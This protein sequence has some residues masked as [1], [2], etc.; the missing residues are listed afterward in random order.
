MVLIELIVDCI[1][2]IVGSFADF[3]TSLI[4]AVFSF[5]G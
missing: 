1:C 4:E 3:L 5:F 2:L